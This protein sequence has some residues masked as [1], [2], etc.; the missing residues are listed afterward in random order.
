M[1]TSPTTANPNL[2]ARRK[3][4]S[5]DNNSPT[6]SK[7]HLLDVVVEDVLEEVSVNK[8]DKVGEVKEESTVPSTPAVVRRSLATANI[9]FPIAGKMTEI[10]S[11]KGRSI[12]ARATPSR[13]SRSL[14]LAGTISSGSSG[15]VEVASEPRPNLS[16]RSDL[17]LVLVDLHL[18][19]DWILL[20]LQGVVI[21][22]HLELPQED[23]LRETF[24]SLLR[25]GLLS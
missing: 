14:D 17:H 19:E 4:R 23:Y 24:R 2:S 13:S 7:T 12:T 6:L 9:N 11:G 15:R 3:R 22:L 16:P 20:L 10:P 21:R 1:P 5:F 18:I 8:E 25:R